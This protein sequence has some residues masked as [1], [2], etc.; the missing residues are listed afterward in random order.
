MKTHLKRRGTSV[1]TLI[2]RT[3][4]SVE[5]NSSLEKKGPA[6]DVET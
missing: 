3:P 4:L 6:S 2:E 5:K 1:H